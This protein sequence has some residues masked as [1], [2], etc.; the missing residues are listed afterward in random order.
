MPPTPQIL[1]N[2][3]EEVVKKPIGINWI[4]RFCQRY[5]DQIKSLYLRAIDQTRQI[6]D[7]SPY[8][9]HFYRTVWPLIISVAN[10]IY[11]LIRTTVRAKN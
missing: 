8:F 10:N 3:V 1:R 6:A 5:Q 2:I 4:Y 9:E 11:I 7:N